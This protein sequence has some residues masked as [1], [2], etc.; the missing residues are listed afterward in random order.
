VEYL[1]GACG[2]SSGNHVPYYQH[3]GCFLQNN[4]R[5]SDGRFIIPILFKRQKQCF[6]FC[7]GIY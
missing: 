3:L 4:E 1:C 6:F 2:V 5:Y 7:Q